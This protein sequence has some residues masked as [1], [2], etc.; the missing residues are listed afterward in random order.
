MHQMI[1]V[2]VVTH[3]SSD[4]VADLL[5]SL[6]AALDG[7][8]AQVVVV[9]NASADDTRAIVSARADCLLIQAD[10][11]GYSAGIN[12]GVRALAGRGPILVL[13]PDVRLHPGC[14][15][16]L[17]E[18]LAVPGTGIVAPKVLDAD[19]VLFHSLRREPSLGR[20]LGLSRTGRPAFSEA[21]TEPSAYAVSH[22]VDWA[23]GAVVLV[24]RDCHELLHGWDE[25][26]FLYSEETDLCLRAR[27]IGLVTRYVP[28]AVCTHIGG[29]SGQSPTTH[30]MQIV[31]RVRLYRR[32]NGAALGA[33]YFALALAREASWVL[34]GESRSRTAIES[35]VF[36][37]RRPA[38]LNCSK[39]FLPT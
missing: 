21:V 2:V 34:R 32:R 37:R 30:S 16:Q 39:E 14:V 36:P 10:N 25:S 1:D 15:R 12:R 4:V 22:T 8:A 27:D 6:P 5:D 31:N 35:L 38:E 28:T 9:D 26:F 3:N 33:V 19:G 29:G 20:A 23:L 24:S 11:L 17:V 18:A 7:L 13:N